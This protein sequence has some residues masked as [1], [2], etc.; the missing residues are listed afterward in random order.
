MPL[1]MSSIT[2]EEG[3]VRASEIGKLVRWLEYCMTTPLRSSFETAKWGM[4]IKI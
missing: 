1:Q 2:N 3:A 4:V